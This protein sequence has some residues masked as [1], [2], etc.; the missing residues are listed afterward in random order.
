MSNKVPKV[1]CNKSVLPNG[2]T[3]VVIKSD[4]EIVYKVVR[5]RAEWER[6]EAYNLA[7]AFT[8]LCAHHEGMN[9]DDFKTRCGDILS[10]FT[11]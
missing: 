8:E 9:M 2:N 1:W 10:K 5:G 4:K 11:R 6:E 7:K 3:E